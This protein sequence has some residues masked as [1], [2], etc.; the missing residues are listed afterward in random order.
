M[1][2]Q[3]GAEVAVVELGMNHAGEIRTLVGVA[4]PDVRV[5]TNVGTAHIEYF[6][7]QEAIA[8]AKAE[9]L[10][11]AG[12]DTVAVVNA[13]DPRVM[14]HVAGFPG[15]VVTFGVDAAAA[16]VGVDRIEDDGLAGQRVEARTPAG[17]VC[18]DLVLA[19]RANLENVLAAV[20][21]AVSMGVPPEEIEARAVAIRPAAHRG[22]VARLRG[23]VLVYDDSYNASPTALQ[24]TLQLIGSDRSGRRR[25]AF[26]GE[27]LELGVRSEALHRECGGA[28]AQA[29]VAALVTV[30]GH[31]AR[32]LGEAA[33]ESGVPRVAVRHVEAS[34]AAAV[35]VPTVV[36]EGDLVLVKGSNSTR[37]T[38]VVE[39]LRAEF[40]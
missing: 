29:G 14:R 32:A 10:E 4:E 33:A 23:D 31:S 30:G 35:L 20:A 26:L 15:R 25:V 5:W 21:V 34:D 12:P 9:V 17:P 1:D 16:D 24:R 28:V 37:M 2:L 39:R 6:G 19:G 7:S 3:D 22:E 40:A 36:Q 13:D 11:L 18:L 8:E 27:M 38:V